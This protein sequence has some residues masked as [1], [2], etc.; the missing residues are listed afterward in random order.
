MQ[1][2]ARATWTDLGEILSSYGA[3]FTY[4]GWGKVF[5]S[6]DFGISWVDL[7]VI[8][9]S[10]IHSSC[11]LGHGIA[12]IGDDNG[13]ILRSTPAFGFGD[14]N[15]YQ[16]E[17]LLQFGCLGAITSNGTSYHTSRPGTAARRRTRSASACRVLG[18]SATST[19]SS[20]SPPARAAAP[21]ATRSA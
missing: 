9:S 7:G 5:R 10:P 4:F 15:P 13:H 12:V 3:S 6:T 1:N 11:Y 19:C 16:A 8:A 17:L 20:A 2:I 18:S 21:T 14:F